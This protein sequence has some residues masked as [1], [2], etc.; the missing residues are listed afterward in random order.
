MW[1]LY[2]RKT[3]RCC[4]G[5]IKVKDFIVENIYELPVAYNKWFLVK[6]NNKKEALNKVYNRNGGEFR[7]KDFTVYTL[8]EF[9]KFED[10]E[11]VVVI[12]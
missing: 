10:N 9:Y 7:K 2:K 4:K 5:E 1:S 11:D 12:H 6:A 8:K 3:D